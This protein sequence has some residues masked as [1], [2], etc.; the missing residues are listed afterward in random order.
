MLPWYLMSERNGS[1]VTTLN[2]GFDVWLGYM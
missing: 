2:A 1:K